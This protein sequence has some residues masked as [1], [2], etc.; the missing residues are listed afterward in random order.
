MQAWPHGP[1]I[2]QPMQAGLSG[3]VAVHIS[4]AC[5][6]PPMIGRQTRMRRYSFVQHRDPVFT[7]TD[8]TTSEED[9]AWR[10]VLR[11]TMQLSQL[12]R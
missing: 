12:H 2:L 6:L 9:W 1:V 7:D 8:D 10:Q 11:R 3:A 5:D 4:E